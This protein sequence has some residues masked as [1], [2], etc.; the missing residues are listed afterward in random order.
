MRGGN[1]LIHERDHVRRLRRRQVQ[2]IR[3]V[4]VHGV[5]A[6]FLFQFARRLLVRGMLGGQVSGLHRWHFL[7]IL[8]S[9]KV[10]S[11]YRP[12]ELRGMRKGDLRACQGSGGL[13]SLHGSHVYEWYRP[14]QLHR[15]QRGVLFQSF[16][17]ALREM[18]QSI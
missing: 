3:S 13:Q 6:R 8:P 9:G 12:N 17:G 11:I 4:G 10:F 7:R 14:T 5:R 2:R 18:P 1:I 16:K 15:L